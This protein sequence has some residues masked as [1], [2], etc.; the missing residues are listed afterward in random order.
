MGSDPGAGHPRGLAGSEPD[1]RYPGG[2]VSSET[3]TRYPEGLVDSE[4]GTGHPRGLAG[5][6]SL[7]PGSKWAV[8]GWHRLGLLLLVLSHLSPFSSGLW[9]ADTR[10]RITGVPSLWLWR[11]YCPGFLLRMRTGLRWLCS[12]V[13]PQI[14]PGGPGL[15]APLVQE[16][17][18]ASVTRSGQGPEVLLLLPPVCSLPLPHPCT[19][20]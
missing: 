3:G 2:L 11:H 12:F 16:P 6:V 7:R 13:K 4:P 1:A 20:L 18:P 14:L 19:S 9:V 8:S 5:S 17:V 15:T 10:D